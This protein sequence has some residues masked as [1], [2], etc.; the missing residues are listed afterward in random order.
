MG[1]GDLIAQTVV[2]RKDIKNVNLARTAQFAGLGF[3]L[4]V[5]IK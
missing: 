2:D 4:V 5:R 3:F 1:T